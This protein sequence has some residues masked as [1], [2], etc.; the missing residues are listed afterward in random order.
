MESLTYG[1]YVNCAASV[2]SDLD[3]RLVGDL[4]ELRLMVGTGLV[5]ENNIAPDTGYPHNLTDL[6]GLEVVELGGRSK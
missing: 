1:F 2:R 6:F 4:E 3:I 5:D